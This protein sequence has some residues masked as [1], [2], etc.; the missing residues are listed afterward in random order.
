MPT[1]PTTCSEAD[2]QRD[3]MFLK[4]FLNTEVF[5]FTD[6]DSLYA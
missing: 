4:L 6:E 2:K 3:Q 1:V 5:T